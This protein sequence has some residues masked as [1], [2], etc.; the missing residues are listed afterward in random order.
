MTSSQLYAQGKGTDGKDKHWI[1]N[2]KFWDNVE[3]Y[4]TMNENLQ[5]Y[6]AKSGYSPEKIVY[7]AGDESDL[8]Y[9]TAKMTSFGIADGMVTAGLSLIGGGLGMI[10][11]S[12]KVSGA[13]GKIANGAATAVEQFARWGGPT[14]STAGIANAYARGTYQENVVNN[15]N[16]LDEYAHNNANEIFVD[17]YKNDTNFKKKVD[18]DTKAEFNKLKADFDRQ[19]IYNGAKLSRE[20][21]TEQ[22]NRLFEQAANNVASDQIETNYQNI[23]NHEG[24]TNAV[25]K[26]TEDATIGAQVAGVTDA[27]KYLPVSELGFIIT[28]FGVPAAIILPPSVPA[29]GPISTK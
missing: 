10:G 17:L 25:N 24:Y 23:K 1:L 13:L 26:A 19:L 22:M 9:E 11:N 27:L 3:Q 14:L 21:Y 28:S 16:K 29:P 2:N 15:L 8:F 7:K 20:E 4:G 12:A 6:Y 5:K 18:S